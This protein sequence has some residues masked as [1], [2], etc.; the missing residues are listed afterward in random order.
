M[1]GCMDEDVKEVCERN[2]LQ[3]VTWL[4]TLGG[5]STF[6]RAEGVKGAGYVVEVNKEWVV[7]YK[8]YTAQKR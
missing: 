3:F 5:G 2:G 4:A 8:E 6:Y 7:V 1:K